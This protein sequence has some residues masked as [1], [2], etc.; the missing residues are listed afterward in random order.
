MAPAGFLYRALSSVFYIDLGRKGLATDGK[1]HE[2]RLAY[3]RGISEALSVFQDA[4]ASADCETLILTE[5][6]FLDQELQFCDIADTITLNSL[7]K[8]IASF[9]D[10]LRSLEVV[11]D[12]AAYQQAEKTHPT[13]KNRTNGYPKDAFHQ[14]CYAHR[15]RLSNS[16]RTPGIS[17]KEKAILQQR[18]TNM[19]TAVNSYIQK[20]KVAM[21]G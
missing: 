1:E 14:A 7:T 20:Q 21:E 2:G 8:A 13:T 11:N 12:P 17:M 19:K 4:Q 16:L 3:E 6:T 18:M 10:A 5:E 9:E 15:T